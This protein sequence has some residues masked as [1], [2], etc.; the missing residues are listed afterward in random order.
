MSSQR[1]LNSDKKLLTKKSG[2]RPN[3]STHVIESVK[4]EEMPPLSKIIQYKSSRTLQK[5]Y[6]SPEHDKSYQGASGI[7]AERSNYES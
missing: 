3:D 5:K 2:R 4:L 1:K 7:A 6:E